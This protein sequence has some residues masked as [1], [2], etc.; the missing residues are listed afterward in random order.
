ML[1]ILEGVDGSGKSTLVDEFNLQMP[2]QTRHFRRGPLK[3]HPLI[4][5]LY[6]LLDYKPMQ[7]PSI[8][9]DRWH[10]GELVY[11]PLY[12]GVSKLTPAMEAYIDAFLES[13][14][15]LK[16]WV[17]TPYETVQFRLQERGDDLLQEQHQRL[18]WDWYRDHL[19]KRGWKPIPGNLQ[20][21]KR[22]DKV[23]GL[24]HTAK[25][26]A[27]SCMGTHYPGYVGP[28]SPR[29]VLFGDHQMV[30][31]D[32]PQYNGIPW[33]PYEDSPGHY[34]L[35]AI[36][37]QH[38]F[39]SWGLAMPRM[40]MDQAFTTRLEHMD[41][42]TPILVLFGAQLRAAVRERELEK[43]FRIVYMQDPAIGTK[44]PFTV[45]R[46]GEFLLERIRRA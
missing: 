21:Q 12:R 17:D 34:V 8:I 27:A 38:E 29:V 16:L 43:K 41:E 25:M 30:R 40:L 22:A 20:K 6:P 19:P 3:N 10:V 32:R 35:S 24:I 46:Y 33:V 42:D 37:S 9:A 45:S 18:V 28:A 4:E 36:V 15:A 11:G 44:S 2:D 23:S 7:E 31:Q 13:R 39:P 14:G 1:V 26:F 5:Y